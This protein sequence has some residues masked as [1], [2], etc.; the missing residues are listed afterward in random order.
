MAP[1]SPR[2]VSLID[3]YPTLVE[4]AG[5]PSRRG[6]DGQSLVPLLENPRVRSGPRPVL[7]TYGYRNHSV[8]TERWRYIEYHDGGRE[9]YDH[10]TGPERVDQPGFRAGVRLPWSTNSQAFLPT[11]ERQVALPALAARSA[12]PRT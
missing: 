5:V 7:T 2:P 1:S 10:D 12:D 4:L 3:L 8:R 11:D 6:L 9:L